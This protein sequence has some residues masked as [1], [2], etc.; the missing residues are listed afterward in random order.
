MLSTAVLGPRVAAPS[1]ALNCT[2][3]PRGAGLLLP[4]DGGSRRSLSLNSCYWLD[5]TTLRRRTAR[6]AR[7]SIVSSSMG[8]RTQDPGARQVLAFLSQV[9]MCRPRPHP[10]T[11][12]GPA[13][14][15]GSA[16]TRSH[17][18]AMPTR[19]GPAHTTGSAHARRSQAQRQMLL[20][21]L[22]CTFLD[23]GLAADRCFSARVRSPSTLRPCTDVI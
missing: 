22:R 13:H 11:R 17:R 7:P 9:W 6:T 14:T 3:L 16:H 15:A 1:A 8:L 21:T 18:Q 10:P 12:A 23:P 19:A 2:A 4:A 20:F 5:F